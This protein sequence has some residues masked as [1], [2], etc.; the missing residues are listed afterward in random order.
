MTKRKPNGYWKSWDNVKLELE[1]AIEDLGH[2]P[3]SEE[4][5]KNGLHSLAFSIFNHHGGMQS[6]RESFGESLRTKPADYWKNYDNV[7]L[8]ARQILEEIGEETLPPSGKLRSLGYSSFASAVSQYHGGFASFRGRLGQEPLLQKK[9]YWEDRENIVIEVKRVMDKEGLEKVPSK[10][11]LENNGY[12]D[13][14]NAVTRHGGGFRELRRIFKE[15]QKRTEDGAWQDYDFLEDRIFEAM[16]NEGWDE[17]PHAD[18]LHSS[19]YSGIA[20]AISRHHGGYVAVREKLGETDPAGKQLEGM[21]E[22]YLGG[23]NE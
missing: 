14:S 21:L 5:K 15:S 7:L 4:L 8:E 1:A 10:S 17:L 13:I 20:N 16:R 11:Y 23:E 22:K 12:R 19:G 9:G 18:I 2:F 3:S 6:V